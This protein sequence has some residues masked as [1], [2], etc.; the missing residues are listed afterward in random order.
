MKIVQITSQ[1]V[2]KGFKKA[3]KELYTLNKPLIVASSM[4]INSLSE[5]PSNYH[6]KSVVY[7]VLI[8]Q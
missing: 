6:R 3:S 7:V 2:G 1:S 5:M 8:W 4:Q